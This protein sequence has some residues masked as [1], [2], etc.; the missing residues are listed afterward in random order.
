MT[1]QDIDNALKEMKEKLNHPTKFVDDF[2]H[3]TEDDL[4]KDF[5]QHVADT[6]KGELGEM[7]RLVLTAKDIEY[8]RY[9]C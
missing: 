2:V 1:K 6:D 5:I 3:E 4:Y 9:Y 7:A 8:T